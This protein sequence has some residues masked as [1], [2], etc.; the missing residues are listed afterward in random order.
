LQNKWCCKVGVGVNYFPTIACCVPNTNTL[1]TVIA[2]SYVPTSQKKKFSVKKDHSV[3]V[4]W[5]KINV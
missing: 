5:A 1:M 4:L 2:H 3:N